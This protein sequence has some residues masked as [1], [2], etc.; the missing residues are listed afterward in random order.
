MA[1]GDFYKTA[2]GLLVPRLNFARGTPTPHPHPCPGCCTAFSTCCNGVRPAQM[3]VVISGATSS[4]C[5]S[6]INDTF[7]LD[8]IGGLAC[9]WVFF[10]DPNICSADRM[11][12]DINSARIQVQI[13]LPVE[14]VWIKEVTDTVCED[15]VNESIPPVFGLECSITGSTCL[16][17][18]V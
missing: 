14:E 15:L 5:C 11:I 12:L 18:A 7:I 10:F 4:G 17:S 1:A 6:G 3:Q 13:G 16:V 8:D 9:A 2:S